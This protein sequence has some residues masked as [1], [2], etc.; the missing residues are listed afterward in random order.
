[1]GVSYHPHFFSF[2]DTRMRMMDLKIVLFPLSERRLS[3]ET[4]N[5]NGDARLDLMVDTRL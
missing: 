5:G 3:D 2:M 1:M 4:L